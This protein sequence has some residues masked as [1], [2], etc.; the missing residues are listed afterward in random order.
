MFKQ[1]CEIVKEAIDADNAKDYRKAFNQYQ[2]ALSYFVHVV[3]CESCKR[4]AE[5]TT[6]AHV[7]APQSKQTLR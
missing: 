1:A 3:K 2:K 6:S 7:E 5:H 4:H